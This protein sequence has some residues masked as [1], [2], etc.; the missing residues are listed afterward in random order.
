MHRSETVNFGKIEECFK[1]FF[2]QKCGV[3]SET[4]K[5]EKFSRQVVYFF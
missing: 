4:F 1:C 2:V 3:F 5:K